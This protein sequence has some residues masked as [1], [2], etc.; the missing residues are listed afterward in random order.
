MALATS[1]EVKD[2]SD[3]VAPRMVAGNLA[4]AIQRFDDPELLESGKVNIISLEAI[5]QRL[6]ARWPQK[7]EQVYDHVGRTLEKGVG[8]SG[9]FARVS[10]T[11]FLICQ[12]DMGR[13]ASQAS[14]LRHLREIL[15]FFLGDAAA[16]DDGV[17]Q[18][19]KLSAN[20]IVASKV[21]ARHAE[22]E[23]EREEAVR[24]RLAAEALAQEARAP[25]MDQ[26]S[27]FVATD[28]RTLRV[29]CALEPVFELKAFGRIGFRMA[30]RVLVNGTEEALSPA[31]IANLSRA[32][33]LRIDLATIARGLD[34]LK[35]AENAEREPSLIVP[36]SYVTLSNQ[37]ARDQ[38]AIALKT[39]S[40]VVKH[41][42]ISDICD[43]EGVPQVALLSAVS[44][45]RPFSLFVVGRLVTTPPTSAILAQ[46]KNGGL[47]ALSF[48]CPRHASEGEFL[49]WAK[50]TIEAAKTIAKPVLAYGASSARD[51]G[52][53]ALL[54]ATHASVRN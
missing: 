25:T 16:A 15:N 9:Y 29:S 5:A 38:I 2:L 43:I 18:V 31:A 35:S 14:C 39:A 41:G 26:W 33:L 40:S 11:D 34:R 1:P 30:R 36:L 45:I 24:Q 4:S 21:D 54:G 53:M 6:G 20:G 28:G 13:F 10:E 17:H 32:D 12:P 7:R 8:F 37:R 23:G 49:E 42:I 44:L 46:L 51:A 19:I 27:P 48:E 3:D 22:R 47:H 50:A 52:M